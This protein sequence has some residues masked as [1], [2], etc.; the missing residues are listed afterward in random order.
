LAI[1]EYIKRQERGRV[2]LPLDVSNETGVKEVEELWYE[3]VP[4]LRETSRDATV[5]IL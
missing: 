4:K 5:T 2:Q 1:E 3:Y